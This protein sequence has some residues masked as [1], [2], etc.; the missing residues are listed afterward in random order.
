[1]KIHEIA[2]SWN[3]ATVSLWGRTWAEQGATG[4]HRGP[5]LGPLESMKSHEVR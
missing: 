5:S 2:A 1:M 3:Q 4:R